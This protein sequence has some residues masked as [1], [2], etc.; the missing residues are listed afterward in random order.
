MRNTDGWVGTAAWTGGLA[1]LLTVVAGGIWTALL[2]ANL[3]TTPAVPWSVA[4]MAPVLWSTWSYLGGGWPPGRT[5]AARRGY[6][7]A[8]RVSGV[9]FTWAFLAGGLSIISLAGLWI[10]LFRLVRI[11]GN[12]VPDLSRFPLITVVAI[13][14]MAS[15]VSSMAEEAGFRGYF[16]VALESRFHGAAAVLIAALVIAPAHAA[17]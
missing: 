11:P 1:L 5:A 4:A 3:A 2:L 8:R 17:T 13:L 12:A 16:Q 6:L 10:V 15:P 14:A 7:R 9:L